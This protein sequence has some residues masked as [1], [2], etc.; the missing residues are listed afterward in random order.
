MVP[1]VVEVSEHEPLPEVSVPLHDALP[2][3]T[4]TLPVAALPLANTPKVTV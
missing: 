4:V 2:S 3:L 1:A